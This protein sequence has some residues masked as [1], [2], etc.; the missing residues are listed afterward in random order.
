MLNYFFEVY[1][2][3][4]LIVGSFIRVWYGRKYKQDRKAML[5][6]E[7]LAFTLLASLWGIAIL[8]PVVYLFARW[9]GFADYDLPSWAG[10]IGIAIFALGL[11]VLSRSHADLGQNWHLT[12]ELSEDHTLNT[13]GIFQHIRHPMYS[14]HWLWAIA[15][16]LLIH[17]WIAGLAS[18]VVFI[19]IYLLRVRREE[20]MMLD[21]FGDEYR[22]YMS[23]SGRI[24]PRISR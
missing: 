17:N 5:R 1:Y 2:L 21:Q 16:I 11:W 13:A 4:C 23:R 10:F 22:S 19:P 8:L 9:P 6:E 18:L 7:G 20:L 12:T 15:Q 24:F 3:L 14:A